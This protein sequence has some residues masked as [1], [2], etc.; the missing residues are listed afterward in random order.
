MIIWVDPQTALSFSP[1]LIPIMYATALQIGKLQ[2]LLCTSTAHLQYNCYY[3]SVATTQQWLSA[4]FVLPT[5]SL[6]SYGSSVVHTACLS[7]TARLS[8]IRIICPIWFLCP[9]K[10]FPSVPCGSPGPCRPSVYDGTSIP[11]GSSVAFI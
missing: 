7:H 9:S 8:H 6:G 10:P 4:S 3:M 5:V 11:Y 2:L 1:V